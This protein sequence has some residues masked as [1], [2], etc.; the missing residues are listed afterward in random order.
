M[1]A[2][3]WCFTV[4]NYTPETFQ[5]VTTLRENIKFVI[6]AK[7]VGES[8]TPHLQGYFILSV[9]KTLN[10]AK[11]AIVG[12]GNH[13]HM[14]KARGGFQHNVDYIS[15]GSMA[16]DD[17]RKFGTSHPTYGLNADV[18]EVGVRPKAVQAK[19]ETIYEVMQNYVTENAGRLN[20]DDMGASNFQFLC[21]HEDRFNEIIQKDINDSIKCD[22]ELWPWQQA[23]YDYWVSKKVGDRRILFIVD[24]R[25]NSGKSI[26]AKYCFI[27]RPDT[28]LIQIGKSRDMAY[29][30]KNSTTVFF[31]N[32][33]RKKREHVNYDFMEDLK[34]GIIQSPKFRSTTKMFRESPNVIVLTNSMPD[35]EA[36]SED[37]YVI[38][39]LENGTFTCEQVEELNA[40]YVPPEI[41]EQAEQAEA[42]PLILNDEVPVV[43]EGD[44]VH[45]VDPV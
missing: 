30:V 5:Y 28:Q 15:K 45:G 40:G 8:G 33:P 2:R 3:H 14:E 44:V 38:L 29:L 31:I 24:P 43:H 36:L 13:A 37:R 9:K 34:D 12:I 23:V 42:D 18:T 11:I 22:I 27:N 20:E 35:M 25:G 39:L 16:K 4:N 19:G 41:P 21:K 6:V 17:W 10:Q 1:A 7:E 26:L 32:I